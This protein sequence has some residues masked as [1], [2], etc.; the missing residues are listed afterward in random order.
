MPPTSPLPAAVLAAL[1][2]M[3][4]PLAGGCGS[5]GERTDKTPPPALSS[6]PLT[7]Q[8]GAGPAQDT[9]FQSLSAGR[10]GIAFAN[11]LTPD[12]MKRYLYNG[13][14]VAIGDYDGDGRPDIYLVG[15]DSDNKLY[16]QVDDLRFEDVTERAGVAG[17]Q[18]WGTGASF[19]DIDNDGDLD[20]FVCNLD[21][22]NL[23]YLNDGRGRFT[24]SAAALGLAHVGASNQAAFADYDRDGDL[25]LYLLTNRVFSVAEE[26]AGT[27]RLRLVEGK[28]TV[29]PEMRDQYMVIAGRLTQAGQQDLLYHQNDD[30]TFT[31]VSVEAGI[32]GFDMGLSATWWDYNGD[33]WPDLY[34]AN[35]LKTPDHLYHNNGDGTFTDVIAQVVSHTPWASM[36]ADAA[37]INNDGLQDLLVADM[38]AT[39]HFKAKA[40]MGEMDGASWFLTYGLPRQF[41]RNALYLNT[42]TTRFL[43]ASFLAGVSN[44]DWTWSVKFGDLDNDGWLDLHVTNGTAQAVNDSDWNRRIEA[45]KSAG[46][47]DEVRRMLS[48]APPQ[49]EANLAFRNVDGERFDDVSHRWGLDQT[50]VS[51]GAAFADLDRDGDLDI[52]VNN[53]DAPAAV[54]RNQGNAGRRV[55]IALR[56]TQSNRM[57]LG[58]V[59]ELRTGDRTQMR[60]LFPQRG[61]L[62]ADE[63]L[64]HFG[65]GK[66]ATIDELTVRWPSGV[67]QR[68]SGLKTDH[69]HTI[70]EPASEPS[71]ASADP[72]VVAERPSTSESPRFRTVG[73]GMGVHFR[74]RERT[75]DDY[76][77]EPLSTWGQ[78]TTSKLIEWLPVESQL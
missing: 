23:L 47:K 16:R 41:M 68:F 49:P 19:V 73:Q 71:G 51:H 7:A 53:F 27:G 18:A 13:S 3:A 28:L 25:D 5:S 10:T 67:V 75:H 76:D 72:T 48:T 2:S 37:D 58:A 17:G 40:T 6:R 11:G 1:A 21:S 70:T 20:L 59:V 29:P 24:E 63:P 14:G 54:Y 64:L 77:K 50:G 43:E 9:W 57:G 4:A 8:D 31:E 26:L 38:A 33:D 65:L 30:G 42:G 35:D 74:H 61:Y 32:A 34:V 39:T 44:T 69:L 12:H 46:Q 60:Q 45:A 56:G 52:V 78:R 22:A 15:L 55:L 36:G 66:Q 62:S